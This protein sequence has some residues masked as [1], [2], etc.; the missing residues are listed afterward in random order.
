MN[1]TLLLT[2]LFSTTT[3]AAKEIC[4]SPTN[5]F[6]TK[7]NL[8]ASEKGLFQFEE[9]GDTVNPTLGLEMGQVYTFLQADKTNYFHPLSFSYFPDAGHVGGDSLKPDVVGQAVTLTAT[10]FQTVNNRAAGEADC[11]QNMTCPAPMYFV[12]DGYLGQYSNI[13]EIKDVTT[14][15]TNNGLELYK[16]FFN[17][18]MKSFV[19]FGTFSVKLK[20]D[21]ESY[22]A[23]DIFYYCHLHQFMAGRIKLLKNGQ[24]VNRLDEPPMYHEEEKPGEFDKKCGTYGMDGF[25]LP[26]KQCPTT[27]VC[28]PP[29][30]MKDFAQCI[31]A[32]NCH[33]L[34]AMTTKVSSG[35]ELALFL[36]QMIPHHQN[37]VNMAKAVLFT[38]TVPCDDLTNEEDP[39]CIMQ[40]MLYS[41]VNGQNYEIGVMSNVLASMNLPRSDDCVIDVPN[42]QVVEDQNK[43]SLA[44]TA[45]DAIRGAASKFL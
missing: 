31:D 11:S 14:N 34:H 26:H 4:T 23:N 25:Q 15:E 42:G 30:G 28:D 29:P 22:T 10:G 16:G 37:A 17:K 2:L 38:D 20:F 19:G 12:N 18:K 13:P 21:D 45:T 7:V 1:L 41:V 32:M 24:P 9:C 44:S 8:Y 39:N 35:T 33:M 36:H 43:R 5:T 6:T 27:F 3:A 40:A